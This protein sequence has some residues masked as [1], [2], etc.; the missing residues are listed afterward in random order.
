MNQATPHREC[1]D[2]GTVLTLL[3]KQVIE[4]VDGRVNDGWFWECSGCGTRFVAMTDPGDVVSIGTVTLSP[5]AEGSWYPG[6]PDTR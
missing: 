4:L 6:Y 3:E 5:L 1:A 2:C